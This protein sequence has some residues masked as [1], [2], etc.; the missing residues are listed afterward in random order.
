MGQF[1]SKPATARYPSIRSSKPHRTAI[2]MAD[3]KFAPF[4][5]YLTEYFK[6]LRDRTYES[7]ETFESIE[8]LLINFVV[9]HKKYY[10]TVIL[11][12]GKDEL[13]SGNPFHESVWNQITKNILCVEKHGKVFYK[14]WTNDMEYKIIEGICTNVFNFEKDQ[15]TMFNITKK[16]VFT[17]AIEQVTEVVVEQLIESL[18]E[19]VT[20][21]LTATPAVDEPTVQSAD[22]AVSE[23]SNPQSVPDYPD[24][25][26]LPETIDDFYNTIRNAYYHSVKHDIIQGLSGYIKDKTK[27]GIDYHSYSYLHHAEHTITIEYIND[28]VLKTITSELE[29]FYNNIS[30]SLTVHIRIDYI[31]DSTYCV[32]AELSKG[33]IWIDEDYITQ[34]VN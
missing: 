13:L 6:L 3:P 32:T 18:A 27:N 31:S 7:R 2:D 11:N 4:S 17:G 19:E 12:E 14:L 33:N 25:I 20:K 23:P 26:V 22:I 21:Q 9:Y 30:S 16:E 15:S 8:P 10:Q 24:S 1:E 29:D 5:E 34:F 28:V